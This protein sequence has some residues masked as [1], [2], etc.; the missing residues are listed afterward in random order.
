[1]EST[2]LQLLQGLAGEDDADGNRKFHIE[3]SVS[4]NGANVKPLQLQTIEFGLNLTDDECEQLRL[5]V[6]RNKPKIESVAKSLNELRIVWL[7]TGCPVIFC[8]LLLGFVLYVILSFKLALK[9]LQSRALLYII[10][11]VLLY[12][13][14]Y[15]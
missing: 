6:I 7:K 15:K 2:V 10:K 5:T 1:M 11:I 9:F 8:I 4:T 14:F 12:K 13:I 3:M